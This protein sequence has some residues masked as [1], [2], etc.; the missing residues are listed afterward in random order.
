MNVKLAAQIL[1]QRV[2]DDFVNNLEIGGFEGF[3]ATA[4]FCLMFNNIFHLF[5][6]RDTLTRSDVF[7]TSI[8][9]ISL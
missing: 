5:N 7:V 4:K 1:R 3:L 6:C 8:E 9:F 2:H